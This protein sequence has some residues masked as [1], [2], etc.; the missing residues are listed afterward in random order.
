[1]KRKNLIVL[2]MIGVL[3]LA[4]GTFFAVKP[5]R[6]TIFVYEETPATNASAE[7]NNTLPSTETSLDP[8][9]MVE[10]DLIENQVSQIRGL[11]LESIGSRQLMT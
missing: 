7:P 11:S 3:I 2:V 10:M 5:A 9:I 6:N 4:V 1:M 8:A